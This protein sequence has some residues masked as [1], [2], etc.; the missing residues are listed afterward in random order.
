MIAIYLPRMSDTWYPGETV[1]SYHLSHQAHVGSPVGRAHGAHPIHVPLHTSNQKWSS[2][3]YGVLVDTHAQALT[4]KWITWNFLKRQQWKSLL[5]CHS[6][7]TERWKPPHRSR[8]SANRFCWRH[9]SEQ[10]IRCG[11]IATLE[12]SFCSE[13]NQT[14]WSVKTCRS[15]RR[16][17]QIKQI[18]GYF[19][20]PANRV[21]KVKKVSYRASMMVVS[22]FLSSPFLVASDQM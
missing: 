16:N 11:H 1:P 2:T 10:G 3:S 22:C 6:C 15:Q 14:P 18:G 13:A 20:L 9:A 21:C 17:P 8:S 19:L 7:M 4:R 5:I 12:R